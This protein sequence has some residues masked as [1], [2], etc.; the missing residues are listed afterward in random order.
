MKGPCAAPAGAAGPNGTN[1]C[2]DSMDA[3]LPGCDCPQSA[4]NQR[5]Y[6]AYASRIIPPG[7]G[8]SNM[9]YTAVSTRS[10]HRLAVVERG[11]PVAA[12]MLTD[13][14]SLCWG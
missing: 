4:E 2:L 12:G 1:G 6:S 7:R 11:R 13:I 3:M 10:H 14:S 5:C 8:S 9:N